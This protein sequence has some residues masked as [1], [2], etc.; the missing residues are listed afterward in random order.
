M[1]HIQIMPA[2]T[3]APATPAKP[4][5]IFSFRF[6]PHDYIMRLQ[7]MSVPEGWEEELKLW[8]IYL[9]AANKAERTIDTRIRRMRYFARAFN[10]PPAK[11]T[12]EMIFDYCGQKTWAAETRHCAYITL[13]AF[14]AWYAEK[15]K[16]E[17]PAKRLPSVRRLVPPPRPTPED[18]YIQAL[19][20]AESPRTKLILRLAGNLGLRADEISRLHIDDI[21]PDLFDYSLRINGKGGRIRLLPLVPEMHRALL[22]QAD[23]ITGWIFTGGKDGHL[24][25]RWVSK[26]GANALPGKW[27]LH[28]LR[29]RFGT[30]SYRKDR[31]LI[32]VQRLLGHADVSTTQ[33]YVEPPKDAVRNTV[34]SIAI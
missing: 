25:A 16:C 18:I 27:T 11:V 20:K 22:V 2:S 4:A 9:N 14:F 26:I 30:Q 12:E 3:A 15:Y 33:R 32:T 29:H 8:A 34:I 24:S 6:A 31:D 28:T 21:V 5:N 10:L 17:D 7:M 19:E 13:R 23:P 1:L